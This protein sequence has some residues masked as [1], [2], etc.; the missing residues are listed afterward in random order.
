MD[1]EEKIERAVLI[2][3]DADIYTD[4]EAVSD[5]TMDELSEL[6]TTAG[7]VEAARVIQHRK[8][9]EPKT[10][11]GTGKAEE[12]AEDAVKIFRALDGY[13]LSRVDFF[14]ENETNEIVFNE[15]NTLP[16]F[17]SISMYPMLWE[18]KGI[19]KKELVSRLLELAYLR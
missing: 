15:I 14:M 5:S 18:A 12:I 2:G 13:G 7:G 4:A 8:S 16:G 10:L 17:T 19:A 3:L 6:L 9:P 1:R 11:I